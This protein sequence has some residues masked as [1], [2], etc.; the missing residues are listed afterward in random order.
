MLIQLI[1]F[2]LREVMRKPLF[3]LI[4][5]AYAVCAFLFIHNGFRLPDLHVNGPF[6][7]AN[8]LGLLSLG[9]IFS[10]AIL[11]VQIVQKDRHSG[12]DRLLYTLPIT[13]KS[14]VAGRLIS[15]FLASVLSFLPV[16]PA[17]WLGSSDLFIEPGRLGE[18]HWL[19]WAKPFVL[20][21]LP[22]F[23]FCS[24]LYGLVA[25]RS[26]ERAM[27]FAAAALLYVGYMMVSFV[28]G[29]PW[30]ANLSPASPASAAL[31]AKLDPFG[32]SAFYE[33]INNWGPADKNHLL[34]KLSGSL[35][36]NRALILIISL[37][38]LVL[39]MFLFSFQASKRNSRA[40]D[41]P[42][43][44]SH[45]HAVAY[46]HFVPSPYK[47]LNITAIAGL[48]SMQLGHILS[49]FPFYLFLLVGALLFG[50]ETYFQI[51]GGQRIPG[52][53]ASSELVLENMLGV[54]PF[55]GLILMLYYSNELVWRK[56]SSG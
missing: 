26:R 17:I 35:L 52:R 43:K 55:F 33:Q 14:Y 46:Q 42:Q 16:L 50:S 44:R 56:R 6:T 23:L 10:T 7:Y 2:E 4:C 8:I 28:S 9:S 54:L 18:G 12:M 49:R 40:K 1:V 27:I 29:A 48:I 37:G 51:E 45:H 31:A 5:L 22:N 36:L 19:F 53:L 20:L 30:L 24:V 11:A 3:W 32:L 47:A 34:L 21:C 25:M 39:N 15:L 13:T 38:L 41:P